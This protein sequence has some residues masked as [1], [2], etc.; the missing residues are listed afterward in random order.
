VGAS[1]LNGKSLYDVGKEN[2][3]KHVWANVGKRLLGNEN[4]SGNI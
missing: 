4:E 3:E 2:I 1:E